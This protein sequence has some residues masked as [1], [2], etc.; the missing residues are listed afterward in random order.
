MWWVG[1]LLGKGFKVCCCWKLEACDER[2]ELSDGDGNEKQ[3]RD[4][5]EDVGS[6]YRARALSSPT[7]NFILLM[8]TRPPNMVP[9]GRQEQ[10]F[11]GTV[12]TAALLE[13]TVP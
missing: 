1:W 11:Q 12:L 8:L 5:D 3:G 13:T 2:T 9:V 6:S 7:S 10:S 4:G